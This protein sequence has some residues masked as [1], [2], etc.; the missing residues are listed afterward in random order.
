MGGGIGE[1]VRK[2]ESESG[3]EGLDEIVCKILDESEGS[4]VGLV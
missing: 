1:G 4:R 3:H 2:S